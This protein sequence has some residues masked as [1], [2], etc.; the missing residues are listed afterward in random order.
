MAYSEKEITLLFKT[1]C[2]RIEEGEAVR[3]ILKEKEMPNTET[4][5]KWIDNDENKA[6]RYARACEDRA[7]TI[8]EEILT[9][10][11]DQECDVY[12]DADGVVQTNHNVIQRARL[13]VDSR[14]W[15][16]SKLQPT[17]YGDKVDINISREQP[18]FPDE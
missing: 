15:I 3:T 2:N 12:K 16:I 8:F 9:I 17:K 10:A 13:R 1:I 14:K 11:D 5:Y 6:K 7:T 18:L 4:F